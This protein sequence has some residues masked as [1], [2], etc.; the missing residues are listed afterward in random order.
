MSGKAYFISGID[1]N[2]GKS[3]ITNLLASQL[4]K[5]VVTTKL[6]ATSDNKPI[7]LASI[8]EQFNELL[9]KNDIMLIESTGGLMDP[10][11]T[12]YFNLD[13]IKSNLIPLLLISSSRANSINQTLLNIE[14]CKHYSVYLHA[15][16]Y[17]ELPDSDPVI[18]KNNYEY[19][20]KYLQE[21]MPEVQLIHSNTLA[22]E[23][24]MSTFVKSL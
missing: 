10:I 18:A 19:L 9:Q 17:N 14:L 20:Q 16:I 15:I 24:E 3:Y 2:C 23:N 13:Y 12:Y 4:E 22:K 1:I 8:D 5:K 7:D 6:P 11:D 21:T